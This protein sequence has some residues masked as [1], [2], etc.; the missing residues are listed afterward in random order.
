MTSTGRDKISLERA[1]SG[2]LRDLPL[3][4]GLT[5]EEFRLPFKNLRPE[6]LIRERS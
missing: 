4:R 3:L 1:L 5:D 2:S 6:S